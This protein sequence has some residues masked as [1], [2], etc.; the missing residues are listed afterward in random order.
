MHQEALR[1]LGN[2]SSNLPKE[3]TTRIMTKYSNMLRISG[4]TER[5]R[6]N[7]IKGAVLRHREMLE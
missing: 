5:E 3:E 1:R 7:F 2:I 6:W 4:Y